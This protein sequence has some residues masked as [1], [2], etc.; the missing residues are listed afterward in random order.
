MTT[1]EEHLKEAE[2]QI[3]YALAK[4]NFKGEYNPPKDFSGTFVL[5]DK[6]NKTIFHITR[7][8][9]EYIA[10]LPNKDSALREKYTGKNFERDLPGIKKAIGL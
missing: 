1:P 9:A 6:K 7:E 8:E 2:K 10:T 5:V 4:M 3:K